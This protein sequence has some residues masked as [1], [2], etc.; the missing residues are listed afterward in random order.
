M[1]SELV[2]LSFVGSKGNK[3]WI[4]LALDVETNEIV[5]VHI[6]DRSEQGAR[7]L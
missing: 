6:G 3:Q 5:G 7:K 1:V 2:E 4:W